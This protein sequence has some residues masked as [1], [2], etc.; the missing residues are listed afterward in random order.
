M[1]R[2]RVTPLRHSPLAVLQ[3]QTIQ[4]AAHRRKRRA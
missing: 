3:K 1:A 4:R 2:G